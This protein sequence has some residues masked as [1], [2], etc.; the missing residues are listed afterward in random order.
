MRLTGNCPI[1]L[2]IDCAA[3]SVPFVSTLVHSSG[4]RSLDSTRLCF[5]SSSTRSTTAENLSLVEE[6]RNLVLVYIS[7]DRFSIFSKDLNA[8]FRARDEPRAVSSP[9]ELRTPL[10]S[11]GSPCVVGLLQFLHPRNEPPRLLPDAFVFLRD[12][13][14]HTE[15]E[16]KI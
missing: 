15:T 5:W 2:Y 10:P 8:R 4:F 9:R 7:C 12:C 6:P 13:Q 16:R 11:S 3:R 14:R 1:R